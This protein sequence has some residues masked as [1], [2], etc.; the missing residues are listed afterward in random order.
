MAETWKEKHPNKPFDPEVFNITGVL[1]R[2]V[3]EQRMDLFL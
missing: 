2:Q 1:D 3:L